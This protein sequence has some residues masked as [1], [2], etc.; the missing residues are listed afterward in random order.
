MPPLINYDSDNVNGQFRAF[1]GRVDFVGG[2]LQFALAIEPPAGGPALTLTIPWH[3]LSSAGFI[4]G[5]PKLYV[6]PGETLSTAQH[7]I[8]GTIT[9]VVPTSLDTTTTP[10]LAVAVYKLTSAMVAPY[11]GETGDLLSNGMLLRTNYRKGSPDF[12]FPNYTAA[13][14]IVVPPNNTGL[15]G[16]T[17][18]NDTGPITVV[19]PDVVAAFRVA[20]RAKR[21]TFYPA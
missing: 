20:P 10:G 8:D 11:A 12:S 18:G 4:P 21:L 5:V 7:A 1:S 15:T 3:T 17:V 16:V 14:W 9:E 19:A 6:A 2:T 13:D